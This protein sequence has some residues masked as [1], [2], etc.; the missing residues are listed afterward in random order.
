[1]IAS[2]RIAELVEPVLSE[3]GHTLYDVEVAGAT[4][5][6]LVEG[7]DL[8]DLE[9]I[10]RTTSTLLDDLVEEERWY[11]EVSTPGLER[12]LRTPRHYAGAVGTLVKVKTVPGTE[13]DRRIEGILDEA[14]DTGVVVAGRRL[15]Y[16][17]IEQARTVFEWGPE[18]TSRS[19]RKQPDKR[20]TT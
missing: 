16:D 5:R 19:P 9:Q 13:G 1:M 3:T 20:S 8:D 10:S 2:V 15:G 17:E 11:L 7:A 14:D 12:A 6:V 18:A 4:V